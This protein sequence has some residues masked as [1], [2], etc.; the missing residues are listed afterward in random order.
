MSTRPAHNT[1]LTHMR[2]QLQPLALPFFFIPHFAYA[3]AFDCNCSV[4]DV[5]LEIE[6]S[7]QLFN[8]TI[9]NI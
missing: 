9:F 5:S 6:R 7:I 8:F 2:D 3:Y 1:A 4:P